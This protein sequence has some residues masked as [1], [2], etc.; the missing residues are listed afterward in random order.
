M[1]MPPSLE[2]IACFKFVKKK[3]T[4]DEFARMQNEVYDAL[5][6]LVERITSCHCCVVKGLLLLKL[7]DIEI[8]VCTTK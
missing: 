5:E 2:R 6:Q 1:N 7:K 3:K 8:G 4:R